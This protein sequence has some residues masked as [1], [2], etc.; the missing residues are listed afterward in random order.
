MVSSGTRL[1]SIP[2]IATDGKDVDL[3]KLAGMGVVYAYPRTS[4]P[5]SAPIEGWDLIPGARGCTP[6]SCAFRD[7]YAELRQAGGAFLFGISTQDPAYQAE[8][9]TRL[10]LPFPLLSDAHLKLAK[11][12]GLSTFEAGG[13][14]LLERITLIL[15]DGVIVHV[16]SPV[17]EPAK[18]AE[19][20]LA[21]FRAAGT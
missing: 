11:A 19:E 17:A 12:I 9:A 5:D 14:T 13:M 2:L 4:P 7:H 10:H 6:Q 1:P 20:V 21:Y 16:M 3:S 18:N 8:A 15:K